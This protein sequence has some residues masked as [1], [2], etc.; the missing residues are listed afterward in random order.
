MSAGALY[1]TVLSLLPV[2]NRPPRE[3]DRGQRTY[4]SRVSKR[5]LAKTH[6]LRRTVG[7]EGLFRKLMAAKQISSARN[8][9]TKGCSSRSQTALEPCLTKQVGR[10]AD[11]EYANHTTSVGGVH[12]G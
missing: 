3:M 6:D 9:E 4:L 11:N 12:H 1:I 2:G 8:A 10:L 5:K 7:H